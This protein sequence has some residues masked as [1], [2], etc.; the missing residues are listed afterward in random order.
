MTLLCYYTAAATGWLARL[1]QAQQH[2]GGAPDCPCVSPWTTPALGHN[3]TCREL[4]VNRKR[5]WGSDNQTLV[6]VPPNYG[7]SSCHSWDNASHHPDCLRPDGQQHE[8][9][10]PEWCTARWCYV[11]ASN[12]VRPH[13][14]T[15]RAVEPA[16]TVGALYHSY[17]TCGNLNAYTDE[18]HYHTLRGQ[19]LRVSMPGDSGSGYTL[20]TLPDGTRSGS[21]VDFMKSIAQ[22]AGF[23]W[24]TVPIGEDSRR[25]FSSSFTACVHAVALGATDLCIGNFWLTSQRMLI[26][27]SFTSVL[28]DDEM[29]LVVKATEEVNFWRRVGIPFTT[30]L[31]P[32]AW[33][34]VLGNMLFM[35]LVMAII[36]GK[37]VGDGAKK[38]LDTLDSMKAERTKL[39][40]LVEQSAKR[41]N[42]TPTAKLLQLVP[43]LRR[44]THEVRNDVAE[45]MVQQFVPQ[46]ETILKIGSVGEKFYMIKSGIVTFSGPNG[47]VYGTRSDG[48]FFGEKSLLRCVHVVC[49]VCM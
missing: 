45:E 1:A 8:T 24:E 48:E 40:R 4:L 16:D 13:D 32:W 20:T 47:A 31:T 9:G 26:H 49:V 35:S 34:L 21:V 14:Q 12:C 17:E 6:C 3:L 44:L 2:S 19:H 11:D 23:T 15:D 43:E 27:P 36:E 41:Q 46:G 28:Y 18:R 30:T 22:D 42:E 25:L 7:A 38:I 10:A 33:G 39:F 29:V 37:D 5:D